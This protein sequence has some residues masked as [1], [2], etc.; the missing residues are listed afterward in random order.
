MT[1]PR[2]SIR[3]HAQMDIRHANHLDDVRPDF[4]KQNHNATCHQRGKRHEYK[5]GP[6]LSARIR[7]D[8]A[9]QVRRYEGKE[10]HHRWK[11][12]D[13]V[14]SD[15]PPQRG[16]CDTRCRNRV[17]ARNPAEEARQTFLALASHCRQTV[18]PKGSRGVPVANSEC[19]GK[20]C[21]VSQV[22][23]IVNTLQVQFSFQLTDPFAIRV[24]AIALNT[25]ARTKDQCSRDAEATYP[26]H[27]THPTH[28]A[29]SVQTMTY[30][31]WR[32]CS[33][34]IRLG[35]RRSRSSAVNR[36]RSLSKSNPLS[37]RN[38]K[39]FPGMRRISQKGI[40]TRTSLRSPGS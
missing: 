11:K 7:V 16:F 32:S 39:C 1:D 23:S 9:P 13:S 29:Y 38:E 27:L 5:S 36:T 33:S 21:V 10:R 18:G 15:V 34:R 25:G 6:G 22:V 24:E 17:V 35:P 30:A 3:A 14:D 31:P 12:N 2:D 37:L 28:S 40:D 8:A 19:F 26:T 4:T 20:L